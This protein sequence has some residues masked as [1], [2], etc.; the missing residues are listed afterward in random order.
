VKAKLCDVNAAAVEKLPAHTDDKSGI[1]VHYIDAYIKPMNVKL[2]DGTPVRCKRR[3]LK[4]TLS[5]GA[6]KGEGLMRRLDVSM[7]PVV[8]LDAAL[9]EAAKGAGIELAVESGAIFVTI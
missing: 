5:A 4:I 3:G 9:H 7:D 8:M 6:K 2:E 1:G